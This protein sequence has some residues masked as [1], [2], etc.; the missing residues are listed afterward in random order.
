MIIVHH[1]RLLES[2]LL[3]LM[4]VLCNDPSSSPDLRLLACNLSKNVRTSRQALKSST[5]DLSTALQLL[6][7]GT[8]RSLPDAS[9]PS[10]VDGLLAECVKVFALKNRRGYCVEQTAAMF[11][12][13]HGPV[14]RKDDFSN[15]FERE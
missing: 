7:A 5:G 13:C 12:Q 1:L 15:C 6:S 4:T 2:G 11:A 14:W 10:P 9:A 3:L 8:L